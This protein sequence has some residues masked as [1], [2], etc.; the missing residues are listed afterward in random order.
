MQAHW[1]FN[2]LRKIAAGVVMACLLM[3]PVGC[4]VEVEATATVWVDPPNRQREHNDHVQ[5]STANARGVDT[6]N[7]SL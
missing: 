7:R 5:G 4:D 2:T 1:K 3:L 6:R